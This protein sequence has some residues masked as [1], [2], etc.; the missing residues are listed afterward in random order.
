VRLIDTFRRPAESRSLSL[1]GYAQLL[2]QA[3]SYG[4]LQYPVNMK[5]TWSTGSTEDIETSYVEYVERAL[6]RNGIVFACVALRTRVFSEARFAWQR[7]ES[8]RAQSPFTDQHL[9]PLEH[10][11]PGGTTQ[12]L[13]QRM[14]LS[15]D[16]GGNAY[17]TRN[18]MKH[19]RVLRPDWVSI[20]RG[21]ELDPDE[22]PDGIDAT[23][24]GYIYK[25]GGPGSRHDAVPL[26]PE[27]VAH[28]APDPDPL[29]MFRGMSWLT[30]VVREIVGDTAMTEH[31]NKY[32]ENAATPNLVVRMDASVTPEEFEAFKQKASE[33]H[34]G[35]WN[36]YKTM[37]LGGGAD[38]TVAGSDLK[39]L[40]F[41]VVQGHGETR[42][43]AAAGVHPVVVGLSEG[44][45]GSSLNAGNYSQARRNV[46]DTT[47][48]P[49]WRNVAGTLGTIIRR[50]DGAEL[51]ADVRDVPFLR[52]D[53]K[54]QADVQQRRAATIS[55]LISSGFT[56]ES[57]VVAVNSGDL[58]KL[59]HTGLVS[60][61][62][63]KPGA[64]DGDVGQ[65]VDEPEVPSD[66]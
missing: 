8:G 17:V 25:P 46:A 10:P 18:R 32:L 19:L 21:S 53:E 35:V 54:D 56:P 52:Q 36:A 6:K 41:K 61:Q 49:L 50:N 2:E 11:W 66:E 29:A 23:L 40:D 58:D 4:G 37:Y 12:D 27:Q 44:M 24:V 55:S 57:A 39:Q 48:H 5:S 47:F 45:Q 16:M 26:L 63:Q 1:G 51:V 38:V 64:F 65:G 9:A 30:P 14:L 42:I 22:D 60:V 62:L 20:V 59:E 43:A 28:F 3:F 13:L 7:R 15:T 34:D 33:Q 31:K